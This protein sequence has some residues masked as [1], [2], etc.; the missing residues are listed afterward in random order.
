MAL[1]GSAGSYTTGTRHFYPPIIQR[2]NLNDPDPNDKEPRLQVTNNESENSSVYMNSLSVDNSSHRD[3]SQAYTS[4]YFGDIFQYDANQEGPVQLD[5]TNPNNKTQNLVNDAEQD[6]RLFG[7]LNVIPAGTRVRV[8]KLNPFHLY[9]NLFNPRNNLL[10]LEVAGKVI[11]DL[12]V[13]P[14]VQVMAFVIPPQIRL[15]NTSY[16]LRTE[17]IMNTLAVFPQDPI[18]CDGQPTYDTFNFYTLPNPSD[19]VVRR[20]AF[21][22]Q[23]KFGVFY[24]ETLFKPDIIDPNP[25]YT[26]TISF[27]MPPNVDIPFTSDPQNYSFG[28]F[29]MDLQDTSSQAVSPSPM[30]P[31]ASLALGLSRDLVIPKPY[32]ILTNNKYLPTSGFQIRPSYI[33]PFTGYDTAQYSLTNPEFLDILNAKIPANSKYQYTRPQI[34]F[35]FDRSPHSFSTRYVILSSKELTYGASTSPMI[36]NIP[37]LNS[38][39]CAIQFLP[40]LVNDNPLNSATSSQSLFASSLRLTQQTNLSEIRITFQDE[41]SIPVLTHAVAANGRC[42][43]A[44]PQD[45]DTEFVMNSFQLTEYFQLSGTTDGD[46]APKYEVFNVAT[47]TYIDVPFQPTFP[48]ATQTSLFPARL[49]RNKVGQKIL[50]GTDTLNL[51]RVYYNTVTPANSVKPAN[52]YQTKTFEMGSKEQGPLQ[53]QLQIQI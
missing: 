8:A 42:L 37:W 10:L 51:N 4:S 9:L 52:L 14:L 24:M 18:Q 38:S 22:F 43:Q 53:L 6:S 50:E 34:N 26:P 3:F 17:D 41:F 27:L 48:I 31:S 25:I 44:Y 13:E 36:G 2:R 15:S 23:K 33:A 5:L 40:T 47:G 46:K 39:H 19:V 11:D 7:S 28:A 12:D 30:D 29:S 1:F 32:P 35:L 16:S 20:A 49:P 45:L 21:S